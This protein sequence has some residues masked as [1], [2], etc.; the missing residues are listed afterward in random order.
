MSQKRRAP[1]TPKRDNYE[2]AAWLV[3][4]T[5]SATRY[6]TLEELRTNFA[7]V[8]GGPQVKE[9]EHQCPNRASFDHATSMYPDGMLL[10]DLYHTL[11]GPQ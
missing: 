3:S 7:S 10:D 2:D 1:E 11:K 6:K 4:H 8:V 9:H 5:L